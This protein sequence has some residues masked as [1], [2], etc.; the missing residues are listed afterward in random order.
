MKEQLNLQKII[1][2]AGIGIG[3]ISTVFNSVE[4]N[5]SNTNS[6]NKEN[7]IENYIPNK[8]DSLVNKNNYIVTQNELNSLTGKESEIDLKNKIKEIQKFAKSD[9][10]GFL[11]KASNY[12]DVRGLDLSIEIAK[13][14]EQA[15]F[16]FLSRAL[17]FKDIAGLNLAEEISKAAKKEPNMFLDSY[18]DFRDIKDFDLGKE[19]TKAAERDPAN[20]LFKAQEFREVE[21][22]NLAGEISK[23]AEKEPD[24]FLERCN[25]LKNIKSFNLVK[26]ILK[27]SE[28]NPFFFMKNVAF[29]NNIDGLDLD[30]ETPKF[31]NKT[32]DLIFMNDSSGK[33]KKEL[34]LNDKI[35]LLQEL[36]P[37]IF[38][39]IAYNFK[40]IEGYNLALGISKAA[41]IDPVSFFEQVEKYKNI[42]DLDLGKEI[43]KAA[44][45]CPSDFLNKA[46]EFRDVDD[47]NLAGEIS[48][49]AEK[50]PAVF[51]ERAFLFTDINGLDLP[52]E[53]KKALKKDSSSLLSSASNLNHIIGL[54]LNFKEEIIKAAEKLPSDFL[55]VA[56]NLMW[57]NGL[58]LKEEIIKA[59]NISPE[60]FIKNANNYKAILNEQEKDDLLEKSF[61]SFPEGIIKN[62]NLLDQ[63][64]NP[65]LESIK[66]LKNI[67]NPDLLLMFHKMVYEKLSKE[68]ASEIIKKPE[69]LFKNLIEIESIPNHLGA[70]SVKKKIEGISLKMIQ[71]INSLHERSDTE[72]FKSIENLEA[73]ELYTIMV[74]GEQEVFTSSFNGLF[75]KLMSKIDRNK[76]GIGGKKLLDQVGENNFR[77]F[78]KECVSFNRL[79]EFL[80]TMD[81]SDADN[82]LTKVVKNL[83]SEKDVL[84]QAVI[85]ADIFGNINNKETILLL[86]NQ[87][88]IEYE[89]MHDNSKDKIVYGLL[90]SMFKDNALIDKNWFSDISK[91]YPIDKV[92]GIESKELF[93]ENGVCVQKYCFFESGGKDGIYSFENF[94]KIYQNDPLWKIDRSHDG[95]VKI[96]GKKDNKTIEIYANIPKVESYGMAGIDKMNEFLESNKLKVNVYTYRGHSFG[97]EINGDISNASIVNI[98][99]CGGYKNLSEV[100]TKSPHSQ[101]ISTKGTGSRFVNDPTFYEVNK[102]I[103]SGKDILWSNF[104]ESLPD[105]LRNNKNFKDY[106]FPHENQGMMFIK[107]YYNKMAE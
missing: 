13:A 45:R 56:P 59:T 35:S 66:V 64:E 95:F 48:K 41:K 79:D 93:N 78:I 24:T 3:V 15:P 23:A 25:F 40:N 1:K 90:S 29:L 42:K 9:P 80:S 69:I 7:E 16:D 92:M 44:E 91:E 53:I 63:I 11:L 17:E 12:K 2:K 89:K 20:F 36:Q 43:A 102:L 30:K 50:E 73:K 46:E 76:G 28:Q 107:A 32:L 27:I 21:G 39:K 38:I 84:A 105:S 88:K 81:K 26:E 100:L 60:S 77:T 96:I 52:S 14:A 58:N 62:R 106:V 71:K 103:L 49:A 104:V 75:N 19:I 57:V 37:S 86:Q 67:I 65:K 97:F 101:I 33:Y 10:R 87:V 5:A 99:S 22:L 82:L 94:I 31:L 4:A 85:I 72:R 18:N 51:I 55:F 47:L 83:S 34:N 8:D 98:G 68:N 6:Q 70:I 54:D 74:Y 61:E